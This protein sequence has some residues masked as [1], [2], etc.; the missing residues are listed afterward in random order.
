[1]KRNI[2]DTCYFQKGCKAKCLLFSCPVSYYTIQWVYKAPLCI[3]LRIKT[4][5]AAYFGQKN[6][7]KG[8]F[9]QLFS[10]HATIFRGFFAHKNTVEKTTLKSFSEVRKTQIH[11]FLT[12]WAAQ[13][14][15][16]MIQNLAYTPTVYR[17]GFSCTI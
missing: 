3:T 17:T 7:I 11:F 12:A 9:M 15:E 10:A 1:M 2:T 14:E 6:F 13:T 16:F 8:F 5:V 4:W